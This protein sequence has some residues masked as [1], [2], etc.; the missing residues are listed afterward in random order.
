MN[1]KFLFCNLLAAALSTVLFPAPAIAANV[2]VVN[3][4][5]DTADGSCDAVDCSLREAMAAAEFGDSIEFSALFNAPQT[6][7]L[8]GTNLIF[9]S[10]V[11]LK[12]PGRD[13]LTISGNQQ[14]RIFLIPPAFIATISDLTIRNGL[15]PASGGGIAA[16]GYLDL[17]NATVSQNQSGQFGAGIILSAGFNIANVIIS[18]N[19]NTNTSSLTR[20]GGIYLT[21]AAAGFIRNSSISNNTN[22]DGGGVYVNEGS[23][24]LI[25]STVANNI[26]SHWGGGINNLRGTLKVYESAI[27]A[28]RASRE[29]TAAGIDS[30]LGTLEI[31][32]S[33]FSGNILGTGPFATT[34]GAGAL[35]TSSATTI[36][37][38][39]FTE[40]SAPPGNKNTSGIYHQEMAIGIRNSIVAGNSHIGGLADI[41][42]DTPNLF[43][44]QGYNFIG[45]RGTAVFN[46]G[47]DQVGSAASPLSPILFALANNGGPTLTHAP[48]P[49]SPIIDRGSS[50]ALTRD[51][52][53]SRRPEDNLSVPNADDGADIGAYE[54]FQDII[55]YDGFESSFGQ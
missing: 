17:R 26:A 5:L 13:L 12:G 46:G 37:S 52:R 44:S 43:M 6:I 47:F 1:A 29:I 7:V 30:T 53:G 15:T 18:Q 48:Q 19:Q 38:S 24:T 21:N 23:L 39:T 8:N 4:I 50:F 31:R 22:Y 55:L 3:K 16:Q 32:N 14:S 40:N 10:N 54:A 34:N 36:T 51:Q 28:N 2:L 20:G 11:N 45:D 49:N 27:I 33:T 35:W 41:Y 9:S 25:E 42:T